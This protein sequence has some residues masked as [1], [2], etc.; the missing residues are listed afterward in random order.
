MPKMK[1]ALPLSALFLAAI[2][3]AVPALADGRDH[4][5]AREAVSRGEVLSLADVLPKIEET[6]GAKMLEVDLEDEDGALFY[7]FELIRPDGRIVEVLVD[8]A[9]GE[10]VGDRPHGRD[11]H[12]HRGED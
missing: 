3:L 8:A 6:Y 11:G 4:D 7:E 12:S 2:L 1:R 9:S 10:I 5:R